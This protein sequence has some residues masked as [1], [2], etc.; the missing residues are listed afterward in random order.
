MSFVMTSQER[1]A[2]LS[3][4]HVG[5]LAVERAGRAPLAVPVWY[6]HEPGGEVLIWIRR[7]TAKDVALR[8]ARRF[9][10]VA[11]SEEVPYR[12]V[13]AEG[14]VV[15][16]DIPPTHEQAGAADRRALPAGRPGPRLRG[17]VARPGVGA[18]A[19]ATREVAEQRP[20]QDL[21]R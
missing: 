13:T 6:D 11:Q 15:A 19:H 7:D 1:E 18:G 3:D 17:R 9:S 8:A 10:L 21:T 16:D 2:F 12:Y 14:P 4:V 20:E 5:V